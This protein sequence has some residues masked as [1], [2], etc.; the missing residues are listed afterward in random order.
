M[1]EFVCVNKTY[2]YV[3]C[4]SVEKGERKCLLRKWVL[5]YLQ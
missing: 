4:V 2:A 3:R 5:F 1:V